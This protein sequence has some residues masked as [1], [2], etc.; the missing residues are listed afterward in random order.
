[1]YFLEIL[2]S[3]IGFLD[4]KDDYP[5]FHSDVSTSLLFLHRQW[6]PQGIKLCMTDSK[7]QLSRPTLYENG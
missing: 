7:F 3:F 5:N 2:N 6:P 1:M 4:F